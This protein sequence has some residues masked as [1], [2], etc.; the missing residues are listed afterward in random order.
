MMQTAQHREGND[1]HPADTWK[2]SCIPRFRNVLVDT[3][4]RARPVEKLHVLVEDTPQ[5]R[6]AHDQYMVEAFTPNT[7]Q[8]AFADRVR[9]PP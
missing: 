5:V 2:G 4:V 8:Q 7:P 6:F 9:S 1:L 3:L